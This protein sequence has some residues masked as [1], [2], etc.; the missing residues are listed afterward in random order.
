MA[1]TIYGASDD[2]VEL[3]GDI[4]EEFDCLNSKARLTFSDGTIL[5]IQYGKQIGS[6]WAIQVAKEGSHFSHLEI[7]TDEDAEIYSDV[8]HLKDGVTLVQTEI[9]KLNT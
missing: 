8:A 6:I 1:T 9:T 3:E 7:C 4:S 5:E 2:L